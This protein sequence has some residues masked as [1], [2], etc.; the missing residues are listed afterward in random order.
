M[1]AAVCVACRPTEKHL[2]RGEIGSIHRSILVGHRRPIG[3]KGLKKQGMIMIG[4]AEF[5]SQRR[6]FE[7]YAFINGKPM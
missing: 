2:R 3:L 7:L 6:R 1:H 4:A 5:E